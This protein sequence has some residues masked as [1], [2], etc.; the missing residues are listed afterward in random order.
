MLC[1]S[2]GKMYRVSKEWVLSPYYPM[3][4]V[5]VTD[6]KTGKTVSRVCVDPKNAETECMRELRKESGNSFTRLFWK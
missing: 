5:T 4:R 2:L 1:F 3:T 6:E